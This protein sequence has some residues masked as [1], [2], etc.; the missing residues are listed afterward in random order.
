MD[1]KYLPL[2][3][4]IGV[5]LLFAVVIAVCLVRTPL[6]LRY[7]TWYYRSDDAR[8]VARGVRGFLSA[9][10]KGTTELER[11]IEAEQAAEE[12]VRNREMAQLIK[13][14]TGAFMTLWQN[15]R[16]R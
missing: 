14:D 5:V 4:G 3:L 16:N 13:G 1:M 7:Y 8:E 10:E 9:G 15:E 11:L 2:K 12:H 6:K